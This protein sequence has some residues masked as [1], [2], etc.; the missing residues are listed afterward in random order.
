MGAQSY[1]KTSFF[2]PQPGDSN[3]ICNAIQLQS[4]SKYLRCSHCPTCLNIILLAINSAEQMR[5][6]TNICSFDCSLEGVGTGSFFS[7]LPSSFLFTDLSAVICK[8]K[9]YIWLWV[10]INSIY[11]FLAL[12][13]TQLCLLK[14][15]LFSI[16]I[17]SN[18]SCSTDLT[19][20]YY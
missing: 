7:F 15:K 10:L 17:G 3:L 2:I 6:L 12:L 1:C 16:A 19:I 8:D 9:V 18:L 14:Q 20:F 5:V 11:K 4:Q 13:R